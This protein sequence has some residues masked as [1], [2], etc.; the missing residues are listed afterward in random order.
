LR[1]DSISVVEPNVT[2]VGIPALADNTAA[3]F[4]D[5]EC[6]TPAQ[7][8][9]TQPHL[10]TV[11]TFVARNI[12]QLGLHCFERVSDTDRRRDHSSPF[13]VTWRRPD[14]EMTGYDLIFATVGDL[15]LYDRA[16]WLIMTTAVA[17]PSG[18]V[19]RR[20]PPPWVS[21]VRD[22][23][24]FTTDA[25]RVSMGNRT[26][27]VPAEQMLAFTG[28]SPTDP[29]TGSPTI[30][31][32][33]R[34]LWEQIEAA[35]Y[36][37]QVWKRGGRVSSVLQRPADAPEWTPE[38]AERFRADWY[39]TYTGSGPRSGG[40]PILEDGMTL[41]RI[42]FSAHDMEFVDAARLAKE[43]VASA[44]H[45]NPTMIGST[46]NTS[47]SNVREFRRMLYGD[48]LGP[49][50]ARIEARIN[51]FLLPVLGM[52]SARFYVEFNVE[53][54]LKG[55]FQEQTQALQSAVG[56]PWMTADEAR[57]RLNLPAAGGDAESLVLPLNVLIG[58]QASP[59]DSGSQN[60]GGGGK[61]LPAQVKVRAGEA[62]RRKYEQELAGFFARQGRAVRSALG[63]KA[64]DDWW[65]A[66]RWDKEL[67]DLLAKLN[68]NIA[69]DTAHQALQAAGISPDEYDSDRTVNF[70]RKVAH[71]IAR[72]TNAVTKA[73]LDEAR[74]ADDPSDAV[75][76]VF[77]I[78]TGSRA[79]E[80]AA[81]GVTFASAF[82]VTESA[83][84]Y[85]GDRATKT[86]QV[87]SANPRPSHAAVDGETVGINE[88]FSLGCDWPADGNLSEAESCGCTCSVT[89]NY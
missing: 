8:F 2:Y 71:R 51:T 74:T 17:S 48:T 82:G 31:A 23:S 59:N 22:T 30:E 41:N 20:L 7:M 13:A 5:P 73:Q 87:T 78:A 38:Q 10:R 86:W 67:S 6:L 63:V 85:S 39:A 88:Q 64:G 56:R 65:D 57:A 46:E 49:D 54:K 53:A 81:T 14:P 75:G 40:T 89:V 77:D 84:Q 42:D 3:L 70:L 62:H 76:H 34:T 28:Y 12:A 9:A 27:T 79:A 80:S 61:A 19:L 50:I 47:Y 72:Q 36:R 29:R 24:P 26:V 66:D 11:V 44:F 35:R 32:L 60:V 58:G 33:K 43:T 4:E 52:D 16:Y 1:R 25:Y 55:S 69:T 37:N 68:L 18:W 15:L 21:P 45:V 83:R